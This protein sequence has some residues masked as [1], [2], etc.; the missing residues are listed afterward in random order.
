MG[1]KEINR[2]SFIKN[3]TAAGLGLS[4]IATPNILWGKDDRK[5]RMGL[6]GVGLR[7]RNH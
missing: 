4:M 2:R 6:I 1:S 5:V 3:T 7:G